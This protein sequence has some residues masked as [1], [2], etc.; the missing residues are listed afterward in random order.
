[1]FP[2]R[3]CGLRRGRRRVSDIAA[4]A[5]VNKQ[6]I[7]DY[8]DGTGDLGNGEPAE[9]REC[10]R[11]AGLD[12]ECRVTAGEHQRGD[13]GVPL[14]A[15]GGSDRLADVDHEPRNDRSSTLRLQ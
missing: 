6:L 7:S 10:R 8:F 5:G 11:D 15:V 9:H 4:P 13:D 14:V 3:R 12:R 1:V 2:G